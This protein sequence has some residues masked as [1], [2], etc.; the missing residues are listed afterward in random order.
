[1]CN[2]SEIMANNKKQGFFPL[3]YL[4]ELTRVVT[5]IIKEALSRAG[6]CSS[7]FF[8]DLFNF[9]FSPCFKPPHLLNIVTACFLSLQNLAESSAGKSAQNEQL[10][11][12]II[13]K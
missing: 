1:M 3:C 12:N 5:I 8:R 13:S 4:K 6:N 7:V 10:I 9:S 11:S 2:C